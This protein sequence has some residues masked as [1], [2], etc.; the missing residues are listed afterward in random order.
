M[1]VRWEMDL[2]GEVHTPEEAAR[3]ALDILRDPEAIANVFE[4][5][6]DDGTATKIDLDELDGRV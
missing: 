5:T 3:K 4:V 6:N 2:G 1:Q